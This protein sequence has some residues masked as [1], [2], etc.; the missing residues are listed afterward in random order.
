MVNVA[1]FL[2]KQEKTK[3][4]NSPNIFSSYKYI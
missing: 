3:F 4:Y 1:V 2:R